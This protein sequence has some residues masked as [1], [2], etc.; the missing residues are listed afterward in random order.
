MAERPL[1][2]KGLPEGYPFKPEYEITPRET[3]AAITARRPGFVLIDIREAEELAICRVAGA[4]HIPMGDL[5]T[6][7]N[8][9]DA[10][11]STP[12]SL[13]CHTGRR[14]LHATLFLHKQGL[15]GV[16]SVAGGIDLWS[17]DI[18]ATVPRY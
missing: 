3:A 6:R 7:I 8:E 16:R 17:R 15:A 9:I 10:D 13:I 18:D 4:V 11:E 12:I 14:S 2:A 5:A 1:D